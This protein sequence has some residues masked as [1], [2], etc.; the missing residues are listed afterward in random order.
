[1]GQDSKGVGVSRGAYLLAA[2]P[3][4]SAV[5]RRLAGECVIFFTFFVIS[6]KVSERGILNYLINISIFHI[7]VNLS[8]ILNCRNFAPNKTNWWIGH[9]NTSQRHRLGQFQ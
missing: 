6:Q 9:E 3:F 8:C 7:G 5:R 1:M 2:A 4:A